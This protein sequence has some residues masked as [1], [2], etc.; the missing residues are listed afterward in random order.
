MNRRKKTIL[1]VY[2]IRNGVVCDAVEM[3]EPQFISKFNPETC[4]LKIAYGD[5]KTFKDLLKTD[6]IRFMYRKRVSDK[7][8]VADF[9]TSDTEDREGVRVY[10]AAIASIKNPYDVTIYTNIA[11]FLK[12]VDKL[13]KN[14]KIYFHNLA[15]DGSY[16]ADHL[17]RNKIDVNVSVFSR[18]WYSIKYKHV[19]FRDSL[20]LLPGTSVK[21][22]PKVFNLPLK[23][24]DDD[25][26]YKRI[27]KVNE[28]LTPDEVAY[29]KNDVTIVGLAMQKLIEAGFNITYLTIGSF[30]YA[31]INR[32]LIKE[33]KRDPT[34]ITPED[35]QRLRKAYFGGYT[36]VNKKHKSKVI[37]NLTALD[38][39]SMY[40]SMML[41]KPMP[42][43]EPLYLPGDTNID[44][45]KDD[46]HFVIIEFEAENINLKPNKFPTLTKK[47]FV[48]KYSDHFDIYKGSLTLQDFGWLEKNYTY[49]NLK[50][51]QYIVFKATIGDFNEVI[52][53]LQKLKQNHS[54]LDENENYIHAGV[55][56]FAK[57]CLNSMYGKFA[58]SLI[59]ERRFV[60]LDTEKDHLIETPDE[61]QE[62]G[63]GKYLPVSI[64]VTAQSRNALFEAYEL[65][66]YD[67]IAY[68]DT[69]SV[70]VIDYNGEL[71][72][73]LHPTD[74]GNWSIERSN[75]SGKF[76]H[77]KCYMTD[78]GHSKE[79]KVAGLPKTADVSH[80]TFDDFKPGLHFKGV[81]LIPKY[82]RGGI[83]LKDTDFTIK[84]MK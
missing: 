18:K 33:M 59:N 22:M 8:F 2:K 67:R 19:E 38:Y 72:H 77:A 27:R 58:Q 54:Q 7:V 79:L 53:G 76:L 10:A 62:V 80:V 12:H 78:Y 60:E 41:T 84:N 44:Q 66:G 45:Y 48:A 39:N 43:G 36:A 16:I 9:E 21:K 37:H 15:F 25:Y 24:L 5:E 50:I 47:G 75:F 34:D 13:P 52:S 28:K 3:T 20:K 30:V 64:A 49:D 65:V 23:K 51:K 56:T 1:D 69:D 31:M 6:R 73:I 40:P 26:D 71:D 74:F 83:R 46:N 63:K 57:L 70:Y 29:I 61:D 68:S 81:K 42:I 17:L 14:S 11:D 35:D 82:V 32:T 55:R 4:T